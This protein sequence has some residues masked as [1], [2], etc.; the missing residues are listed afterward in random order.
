MLISA[1]DYPGGAALSRVPKEGR[2]VEGFSADLRSVDVCSV[3][4]GRRDFLKRC[5]QGS[6]V[7]LFPSGL[8]GLAF[9]SANPFASRNALKGD[10]EFHLHP[11][12]RSQVP[13]DATLLKT[14]ASLDDFVTEKY[15]DQ[16]A[17]S[18]AE[19]STSLLQSPQAVPAL[20]K[21]L[22]AAFS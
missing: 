22:V 2:P 20:E 12:Y 11:H 21:V 14:Q 8:R 17:A 15:H 10:S 4:H 18:L 6:S 16:I 3:D 5:C 1:G 19:W 13:L 9:P 7:A